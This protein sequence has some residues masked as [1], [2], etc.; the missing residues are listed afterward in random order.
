MPA[1]SVRKAGIGVI[2]GDDITN[3]IVV[4]GRI[5]G[6]VWD[7]VSRV[8]DVVDHFVFCS[9]ALLIPTFLQT[10]EFEGR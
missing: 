5:L 6:L 8:S 2:S 4:R 9:R 10:L 7:C 1:N 3:S